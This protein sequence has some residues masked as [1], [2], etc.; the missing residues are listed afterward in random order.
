MNLKTSLG[1]VAMM[2]PHTVHEIQKL[3]LPLLKQH[4]TN[5]FSKLGEHHSVHKNY[6]GLSTLYS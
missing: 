4:N 2:A 5:N 3:W 6:M 1:T